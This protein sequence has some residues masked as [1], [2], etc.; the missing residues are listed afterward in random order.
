[1]KATPTSPSCA[2]TPVATIRSLKQLAQS[3][4]GR[5]VAASR[6]LAPITKPSG[7]GTI[8]AYSAA[9]G[10]VAS[11]GSAGH[12]PYTAAF[13]D[14]VG[15]PN[16]EVGLMFRRVAAKWSRRRRRAAAGSA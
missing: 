8:I 13:L 16:V 9:A 1:M 6:G 4:G 7:S 5:S 14:Q 11:D 2:P 3:A 12:S 15:E 10:A